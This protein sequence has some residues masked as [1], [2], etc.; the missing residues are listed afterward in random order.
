MATIK[1]S[2]DVHCERRAPIQRS[3]IGM[4]DT[5][6]AIEDLLQGSGLLGGQNGVIPESIRFSI[7]ED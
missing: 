4:L 6:R 2:Y 3:T 1:L 7:E 5:A